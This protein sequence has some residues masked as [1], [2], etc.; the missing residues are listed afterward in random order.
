MITYSEGSLKFLKNSFKST[1]HTVYVI[2]VVFRK[3]YNVH[4]QNLS[5]SKL[6]ACPLFFFISYLLVHGVYK[7]DDK[8]GYIFFYVIIVFL[9]I[10]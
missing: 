6:L 8:R 7:N 1:N 10:N 9:T 2:C 4:V 5:L 3:L